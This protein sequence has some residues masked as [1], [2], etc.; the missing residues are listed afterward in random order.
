[1]ANAV[2]EKW[3]LKRSNQALVLRTLR[4]LRLAFPFERSAR[5]T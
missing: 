5:A 4:H 3:G 1:M 2:P